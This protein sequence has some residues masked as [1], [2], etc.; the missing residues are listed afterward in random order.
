MCV[1]VSV[2][3][4]VC[5]NAY[6]CV[7]VGAISRIC[8]ASDCVC[9]NVGVCEARVRMREVYACMYVWSDVCTSVGV[10]ARVCI[11]EVGC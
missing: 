5:A 3:D 11:L 4:Y 6:M 7:R 9:V 1:R 10:G 2:C 8:R